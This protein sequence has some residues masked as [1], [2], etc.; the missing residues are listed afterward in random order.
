MEE[1]EWKTGKK[2]GSLLFGKVGG[3]SKRLESSVM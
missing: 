2:E 3:V 1:S